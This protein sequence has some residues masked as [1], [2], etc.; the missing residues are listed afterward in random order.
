MIDRALRGEQSCRSQETEGLVGLHDRLDMVKK[1]NKGKGGNGFQVL[2]H[3]TGGHL[4]E[5]DK[6]RGCH[7]ASVKPSERMHSPKGG[8][9]ERAMRRRGSV[10]EPVKKRKKG[11]SGITGRPGRCRAR[12]SV[13][14]DT[15]VK[16]E[17]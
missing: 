14:R 1:I 12:G 2:S 6:R 16:K 7:R 13:C 4:R 8:Q 10:K 3:D 5:Q 15:D 17:G 11:K 9:R